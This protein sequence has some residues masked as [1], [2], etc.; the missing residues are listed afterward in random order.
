MKLYLDNS[1]LNR[2]FDDPSVRFNKLEAE[3]LFLI[4]KL[5]RDRKV[6]L[7]DSAVIEYENS[8]NPFPERKIFI[9]KI[10]Q[11]A[12]AYQNL[13]EVTKERALEIE[14]TFKIQPIDAMHLAAAESAQV[15]LFITSDYNVV[16]KYRGNLRVI[17]PLDFLKYYENTN[18]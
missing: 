2:P 5:V 8:L 15:E 3:I 10:M 16:K 17:K 9:E 4:L 14:K 7:V 12:K 13:N 11:K 18:S 6:I 1:F